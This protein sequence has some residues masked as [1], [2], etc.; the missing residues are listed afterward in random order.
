MVLSYIQGHFTLHRVKD[1][2][3][4]MEVDHKHTY[5]FCVKLFLYINNYEHGRNA[6][7]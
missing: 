2:K 6:K 3:S 5:L 7:L 1:V 4:G